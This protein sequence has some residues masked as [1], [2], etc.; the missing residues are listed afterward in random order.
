MPVDRHAILLHFISLTPQQQA[1]HG[2]YKYLVTQESLAHTAFRTRPAAIGWLTRLGLLDHLFEESG[3]RHTEV[4]PEDTFGLCCITHGYVRERISDLGEFQKRFTYCYGWAPTTE[5]GHYTVGVV[6]QHPQDPETRR[7]TVLHAGTKLAPIFRNHQECD[8]LLDAGL[9]FMP[10]NI[11]LRDLGVD[12]NLSYLEP[13]NFAHS[14]C[15]A[16][17]GEEYS[18]RGYACE[19]P[20]TIPY[21]KDIA[22]ELLKREIKK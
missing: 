17:I 14:V 5:N 16:G 1:Q 3:E 22:Y 18:R 10:D 19:Q 6:D 2:R 21:L 15:E 9:V 4:P 13:K 7:L 8:R 12:I 20:A 11:P